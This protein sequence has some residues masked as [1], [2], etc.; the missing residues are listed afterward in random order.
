MFSD[1]LDDYARN[2]ITRPPAQGPGSGK[3][4]WVDFGLEMSRANATLWQVIDG[5]SDTIRKLN[6]EV[7]LL[8]RQIARRKPKG[9]RPETP[10]EVRAAIEADITR[11]LS[12]REVAK[13]HK[14]SAMTV[15]RVAER[16]AAR[17]G[18]LSLGG[19]NSTKR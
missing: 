19:T 12:R 13:L 8:K 16:M 14:V 9:G 7:E 18:G 3:R 6:A 4:A 10:P 11:G 5:Q 2:T 1:P 15:Q 17:A